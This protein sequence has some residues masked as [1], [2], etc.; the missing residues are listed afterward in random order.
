MT[1]QELIDV[2]ALLWGSNGGDRTGF[3]MTSFQIAKA[4]Q[5]VCDER[6]N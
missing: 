3:E 1:D 6:N 5:E 4:I 2:V